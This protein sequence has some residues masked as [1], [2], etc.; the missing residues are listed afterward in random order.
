MPLI[1]GWIRYIFSFLVLFANNCN[2]LRP[3]LV[4]MQDNAPGHAAAL[5]IQDLN[6]RNVLSIF[7]PAYS[8]DLNSIE[9][10]WCIM[11]DYIQRHFGEK[12]SYD[13]L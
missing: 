10:L 9:T 12:L 3:D 8:P 5:T 6:D 4:L 13:Q 7:W 11:K 2:R 1:H